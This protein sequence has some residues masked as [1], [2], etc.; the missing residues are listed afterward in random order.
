MAI[1]TVLREV[2]NQMCWVELE[3]IAKIKARI[4]AKKEGL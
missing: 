4:R 1:R 2:T 3:I